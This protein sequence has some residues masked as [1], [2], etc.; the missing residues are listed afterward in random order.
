[1]IFNK[2]Q[3]LSQ[4]ERL[5]ELLLAPQ[6]IAFIAQGDD[7]VEELYNL[8]NRLKSYKKKWGDVLDCNHDEDP[9]ELI[10]RWNM[11][12]GNENDTDEEKED[13]HSLYIRTRKFLRSLL[14]I[15]YKEEAMRRVS[16]SSLAKVLERA[17]E[18]QANISAQLEEE[19]SK[20]QPNQE[21]IR[22]LEKL[23]E[24]SDIEIET[25]HQEKG[26]QEIE[27]ASERDWNEKIRE[28]FTYLHDSSCDI[29]DEKKKV[30]LEYHFFLYSLIIP[31]IILLIWL[32]KLY[33]FIMSL[34][35]PINNW[36]C[37]LPY[38]LPVPIFIAI[39]WIF[40][41]Q[42]NR[43]NKLSIAL[44][45]RLYQI[46]YFEG[47]LMTIN[48]L[49]SNSQEAISRINQ[50]LDTVVKAFVSK[51]VK[52]S[53]DESRV[54]ELEKKEMSQDVSFKIIE[55]LTDIIKKK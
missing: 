11:L 12:F 41:V 33:G 30:D 15:P 6:H 18:E 3:L 29:Q 21:I 40:I 13:L 20:P 44:S 53:I 45:E 51:I 27:E 48:R 25:L 26:V 39:F 19:K 35:N 10:S 55:K 22:N 52:D 46:K 54:E 1:M 7:D 24:A 31:A 5:Q 8:F 4:I 37:F 16:S 34:Q 32:C 36:M 49:S 42:K 9:D 43:A 28:A 14:T 47:L 17:S 23:K 38:Y 2:S 50:S